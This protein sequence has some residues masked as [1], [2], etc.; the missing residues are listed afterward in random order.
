MFVL[1]LKSCWIPIV[2]K[3]PLIFNE[4]EISELVE[5]LLSLKFMFLLV[6]KKLLDSHY[7]LEW[8]FEL[9]GLRNNVTWKSPH[10]IGMQWGNI[11]LPL[12]VISPTQWDNHS[13]KSL[14]LNSAWSFLNLFLIFQLIHVKRV[15]ATIAHKGVV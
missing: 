3:W 5:L 15:K 11:I 7:V 8:P 6:H 9:F 13:A 2:L 4:P 1:G 10:I 14:G 12:L